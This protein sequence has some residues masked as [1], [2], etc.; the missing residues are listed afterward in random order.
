MEEKTYSFTKKQLNDEKNRVLAKF[1]SV[2]SHDLKNVVGGLSN[3]S[4][5][6]SKTIKPESETQKK[7]LDLL[8][9]EVITLNDRI[10]EILDRT[11][12][13]QLT[14]SP[15]DLKELILKA[16]EDSKTDGIEFEQQLCSAQVYA[17]PDRVKQ[18]FTNII[19]NAKDAMKNKGKITISMEIKG[20][21]I[22][23]SVTIDVGRS[24]EVGIAVLA[25]HDV[26]D[27]VQV[28]HI[29]HSVAVDVAHDL[30]GSVGHAG[31][32]GLQSEEVNLVGLSVGHAVQV[33]L[34]S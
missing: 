20:D 24:H 30:L 27:D 3:I 10:V 33:H 11:R 28:V 16:I 1:A 22:I 26:D 23:T 9:K 17:D 15:C 8:S 21:N 5:Y 14:K 34:D 18:V 25:N 6:L 4:Y 32:D 19:K 29:D 13:K 7:M 31:V 2:A 12:V